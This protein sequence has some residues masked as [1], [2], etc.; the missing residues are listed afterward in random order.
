[1]SQKIPRRSGALRRAAYLLLACLIL[2][3]MLP[4][5]ASAQN[6]TV[7][8]TSGGLSIRKDGSIYDSEGGMVLAGSGVLDPAKV[9]AKLLDTDDRNV[10]VKGTPGVETI[11]RW[12][13]INSQAEFKQIKE[14][15]TVET[16]DPQTGK[17]TETKEV[18]WA[19]YPMLLAWNSGGTYY[20]WTQE[21]YKRKEASWNYNTQQY[22]YNTWETSYGYTPDDWTGWYNKYLTGNRYQHDYDWLSFGSET[23]DTR[24]SYGCCGMLRNRDMYIQIY[25]SDIMADDTGKLP[26]EVKAL[27]KKS[28]KGSCAFDRAWLTTTNNP[29]FAQDWIPVFKDSTGKGNDDDDLKDLADEIGDS[30]RCVIYIARDNM[31]DDALH[32]INEKFG[33]YSSST[34]NY[35]EFYLY[36]GEETKL[37]AIDSDVTIEPGKVMNVK[38]RYILEEG[39]TLTVAP[40][41]VLSIE[42]SF[43]NNGTIENYGTILVQEKGYISSLEP[44]LDKLSE[45][46]KIICH[47]PEDPLKVEKE[48]KIYTGGEGSMIVLNGGRVVG[49]QNSQTLTLKD[50]A[51]LENFG[52]MVLPRGIDATNARIRNR[53]SGR[54]L[55]GYYFK[56]GIGGAR[57]AQL[58][59]DSG[60]GSGMKLDGLANSPTSVNNVH[61]GCVIQ[62]EGRIR[63]HY[64]SSARDAI[65]MS[66]WGGSVSEN[67]M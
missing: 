38:D 21:G 56:S 12:H 8:T 26:Q 63:A 39:C 34:Y 55:L 20:Y 14:T 42:G 27:T 40:G 15:K 25:W 7:Y 4:L 50:G 28:Q 13:L 30:N 41:A 11:Y 46:G 45:A 58:Q 61:S 18:S 24:G 3:T 67:S 44:Q 59:G 65:K 66:D 53:A 51:T 54:M 19:T 36:I 33:C 57:D 48:N 64:T 1:M 16:I 47:S 17:V 60:N 10:E 37:T 49:M 32:Y 35:D 62:N 5:T 22:V 2:F 52:I 6:T 43:Y 23:F 9:N 31:D 29:Y